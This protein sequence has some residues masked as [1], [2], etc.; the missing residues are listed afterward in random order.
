MTCVGELMQ[1]GLRIMHFYGRVVGLMIA[2]TLPCGVSGGE[3]P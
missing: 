1:I 2:L 3:L